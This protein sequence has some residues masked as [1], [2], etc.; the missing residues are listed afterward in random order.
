MSEVLKITAENL[1]VGEEVIIESAITEGVRVKPGV[2]PGGNPT[3][4]VGTLFGKDGHCRRYGRGL[5]PEV[6][7]LSMGSDVIDGTGKSVKG[8]HS[9]LTA[10][11]IT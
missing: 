3:I 1:E 9:S 11:F 2:E 10:L 7:M 4:A 8:L 6:T 5:G